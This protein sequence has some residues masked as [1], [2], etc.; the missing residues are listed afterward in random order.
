MNPKRW[1]ALAVIMNLCACA[2]GPKRRFT[3]KDP[4]SLKQIKTVAVIGFDVTQES[5]GGMLFD[6]NLAQKAAGGYSGKGSLQKDE[7]ADRILESAIKSIEKQTGWR[8]VPVESVIANPVYKNL[9]R[10]NTNDWLMGSRNDG[11]SEGDLKFGREG[12]MLA[13]RTS[14]FGMGMDQ[15]RKAILRA[16]NVDAVASLHVD[17]RLPY[18][19]LRIGSLVGSGSGSHKP[20]TKVHMQLNGREDQVLGTLNSDLNSEQ[21]A[22]AGPELKTLLVRQFDQTFNNG[23]NDLKEMVK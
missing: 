22:K 19:G 18:D 1:I 20:E 5:T 21:A 9:Y 13:N 11:G 10:K 2:S 17:F 6:T 7:Y 8:V 4:G 15:D 14:G 3:A 23:L 16:L 12:L